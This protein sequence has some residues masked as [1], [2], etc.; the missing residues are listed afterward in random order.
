MKKILFVAAALLAACV[1]A[2]AQQA[3]APSALVVATVKIQDPT[4]FQEYAKLSGA[5]V[6]AH[7]G[8]PIARGQLDTD[9]TGEPDHNV[10]AVIRFPSTEDAKSWYKSPDY[11][12]LI[13][14]REEAADVSIVIYQMP[15]M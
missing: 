1:S 2:T 4:K 7:G 15:P 3:P 6:K 10:V 8:A 14:L 12:A 9:L 11:Q 5:T 13:P